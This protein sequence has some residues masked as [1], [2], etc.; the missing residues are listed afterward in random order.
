MTLEEIL[1]AV[2]NWLKTTGLNALVKVLIALLILFIAFKII[3]RVGRKII[4]KAEEKKHDK[5]IVKTLVYAGKIA[6]KCLVAVCMIGF[7]GIDTSGITALIASLGVCVGLAVNGALS[8]LAGGVL[9]LVTRPFKIDDF[10]EACGYSGTVEDIRIVSTVLRTG[11]NKVVHIPNGALSTSTIVNYST[12]P[13]RRVDFTFSIGYSSDYN[14]AKQIIAEVLSA[15]EFVLKDPAFF[16]AMN[17]HAA[18]S[19]NIVTRAWCNSEHYWDVYF[20]VTE[21][22]KAR[23]DEA[24]IEIPFN[25]LDVHVINDQK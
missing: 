2:F 1:N 25:Q 10:I 13:I 23:F 5:T 17:E 6:A 19:I 15:N 11:D 12:K 18:S 16:I 3:N 4:K 21:A 24:G 7:V 14:K 9:L 22:I 8:N 20:A